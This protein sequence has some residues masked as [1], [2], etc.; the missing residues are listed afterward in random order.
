M[1]QDVNKSVV[2][3]VVV[4]PPLTG[5]TTVSRVV[6][7]KINSAGGLSMVVTRPSWMGS[8]LWIGYKHGVLLFNLTRALVATKRRPY[9][10]ADSGAGLVGT[11]IMVL[12]MRLAGRPHLIHHHVYSY[13]SQRNRLM[14]LI[15]AIGRDYSEHV[16]LSDAME[17]RFQ[18]LY[19]P[20]MSRAVDNLGATKYSME[21]TTLELSKSQEQENLDEL[22]LGFLGRVS[23]EK[24]LG[25]LEALIAEVDREL[26][27][28]MTIAGPLDTSDQMS[29]VSALCQDRRVEYLGALYGQAKLDYLQ[30]LD[31]LLFPTQYPLEAQPLVI[32]EGALLGA[33]PIA[34]ERG[35]IA[36]QISCLRGQLC[37]DDTFV[38]DLV[39]ILEEGRT[40]TADERESRVSSVE[41][42]AETSLDRLDRMLG[43]AV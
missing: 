33:V 27:F 9:V 19:G 18:E 17:H 10:V 24:G 14:S 5:M 6:V 15:V 42:L 31:Y 4:P 32:W 22:R 13:I 1:D 3:V 40:Q 16:L 20:V 30:S 37:T 7:E 12:T 38:G 43:L 25:V 41:T 28:K 34:I 23:E 36:D 8:K 39:R 11:L 2:P 35:S 29:R 21:S 26:E